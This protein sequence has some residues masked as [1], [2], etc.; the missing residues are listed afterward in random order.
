MVTHGAQP[1]VIPGVDGGAMQVGGLVRCSWM[2]TPEM[3]SLLHCL[4]R[5]WHR[6]ERWREASVR[7]AHPH[8]KGRVLGAALKEGFSKQY[9]D[10]IKVTDCRRVQRGS[11]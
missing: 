11:E 9:M 2:K 1:E 5:R 7:Q 8:Q 10:T 4:G 6:N 3:G